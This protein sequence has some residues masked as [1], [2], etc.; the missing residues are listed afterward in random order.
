MEILARPKVE[1]QQIVN[2]MGQIGLVVLRELRGRFHHSNLRL[3]IELVHCNLR[4]V[5]RRCSVAALH[6]SEILALLPILIV[7]K[8][9]L[10][11]VQILL[12]RLGPIVVLDG[13]FIFE[14][15][16]LH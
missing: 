7:N 15:I 2:I 16:L 4:Y 3:H 12:H 1:L 10:A 8:D 6:L 13:L 14:L 5:V 11:V 9:H